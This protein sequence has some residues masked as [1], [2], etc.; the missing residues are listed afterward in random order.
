MKKLANNKLVF[1]QAKDISKCI[2][3]EIEEVLEHAEEVITKNVPARHVKAS[4]LKIEKML[5]AE[6]ISCAFDKRVTREA[7]RK[8]ASEEVDSKELEELIEVIVKAVVEEIE[9]VLED[10]DEVCADFTIDEEDPF[11]IENKL[12]SSIEKTCANNGVKIK[13]SR[14][15]KQV[16][17]PAKKQTLIQKILK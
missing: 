12:K 9:E 8:T 15:N 7:L 14:V 5:E 13:L 4:L 3:A 11:E 2:E 10:A 1:K 16:K 17:K 6:G